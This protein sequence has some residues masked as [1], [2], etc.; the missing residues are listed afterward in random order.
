MRFDRR[1][2]LPNR[3]PRLLA[4][5]LL[6]MGA[7][8]AASAPGNAASGNIVVTMEVPSATELVT[9]DCASGIAD[10]TAFGI[11]QPGTDAVAD[12]GCSVTFGSSNDT[13]K[14]RL[15]QQ[16]GTGSAM[17]LLPRGPLDTSFGTAGTWTT[18][19]VSGQA[20]RYVEVTRTT[21]G[22]YYLLGETW[23]TNVDA[24]VEKRD[25]DWNL[26]PGYGV[27][28]RRTINV[29]A[30]DDA[31]DLEVDASGRAWVL[32]R[33]GTTAKVVRLAANGSL[34]GTWGTSGVATVT[35]ADTSGMDV[36]DDGRVLVAGMVD[37]A[38]HSVQVTMIGTG[39]TIDTT[40]GT[41][42]RYIYTDAIGHTNAQ[43]VVGLEGGGAL[44]LM[45]SHHNGGDVRLIKL[46]PAGVADTSWG[47][48]GF[49]GLL[50]YT[51][52]VCCAWIGDELELDDAGRVLIS[53]HINSGATDHAWLMRVTA[54]GVRD[55]SFGTSGVRMT[56][57]AG[58][59]DNGRAE[60]LQLPDGSYA[61]T[62]TPTIGGTLTMKVWRITASGAR[63]NRFG[64]N[65]RVTYQV[66]G[67]QALAHGV[68]LDAD[69]RLLVVGGVLSGG[70]WDLAALRLDSTRVTQYDHAGGKHFLTGGE[71]VFGACVVSAT[72]ATLTAPWAAFGA[73]GCTAANAA[74]WRPIAPTAA[75]SG[76][77][78]ATTT[79]GTSGAQVLLRFGLH[80]HPALPPGTYT[81]PLVLEVVAP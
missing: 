74:N 57:G 46:T 48:N 64:S 41:S 40:W 1:P 53:G 56:D 39:G 5:V 77:E 59:D 2:V 36:L 18:D 6:A 68:E 70:D 75:A 55:S 10:R 65:G 23:G 43:D 63:D 44:V 50:A 16:D 37:L 52:L 42:G 66:G 20:D 60:L 21:D 26:V 30:V 17:F 24:F 9:T 79:S 32:E 49:S 11:V 3:T 81:A 71:S 22:S 80:T 73:G 38:F 76:G 29:F 72:S 33:N 34:D 35:S 13:S 61:L 25:S 19:L 45:A 62:S 15:Y 7:A 14:L 28:G 27:G 8:V 4:V 31:L 12:A 69:G 78:V 58:S 54:A 51:P 47:T 67:S